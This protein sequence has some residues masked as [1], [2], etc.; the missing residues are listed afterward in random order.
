[1]RLMMAWAHDWRCIPSSLANKF[2]GASI[3]RGTFLRENI[4]P[5]AV[6]TSPIESQKRLGRS[7]LQQA[8]PEAP[9][10]QQRNATKPR[11]NT[12]RGVPLVGKGKPS[13]GAHKAKQPPGRALTQRGTTQRRLARR[14][15]TKGVTAVGLFPVRCWFLLM[16]KALEPAEWL[17]FW[18]PGEL[19]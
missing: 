8:R 15:A 14:R 12:V 9:K 6:T 5:P 17:D 13:L 7:G 2:P 11:V 3:C 10:L 1:M 16:A 19:G 18:S 4:V